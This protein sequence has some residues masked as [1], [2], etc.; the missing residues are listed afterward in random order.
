MLDN[1]SLGYNLL[2]KSYRENPRDVVTVPTT[3]RSGKY[4]HVFVQNGVI[5][6]SSHT[7]KQPRSVISTPRFLKPDEYEKMY[8]LYLR[9]KKGENVSQEATA[10]TVNQVYWYGIFADMG[11]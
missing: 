11:L 4:F 3:N 1:K 7:D 9:R 10:T 8:N 5:Y 6:V 2:V